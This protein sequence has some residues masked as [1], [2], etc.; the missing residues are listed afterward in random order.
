MNTPEFKNLGM[1]MCVSLVSKAWPQAALHWRN[2]SL[3]HSVW[4][5]VGR[6]IL[7]CGVSMVF[8]FGAWQALITSGFVPSYR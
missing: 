3:F 5:R 2:R 4:A 8:L 1:R 6:A 7:L